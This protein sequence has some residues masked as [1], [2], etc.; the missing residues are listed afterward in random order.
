[1]GAA[2][3][4]AEELVEKR[5]TEPWMKKM[6]LKEA[7]EKKEQVTSEQIE[8]LRRLK[9]PIPNTTGEAAL[10]LDRFEI[11]EKLLELQIIR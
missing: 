6:V 10:L 8:Q 5:A 11:T 7:V 3:I 4:K 9:M 1:L 2:Q